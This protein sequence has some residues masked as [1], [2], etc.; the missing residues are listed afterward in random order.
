MRK[1]FTPAVVAQA[2]DREL[3]EASLH[4]DE[5]RRRFGAKVM[6]SIIDGIFDRAA[7]RRGDIHAGQN[8]PMARYN[9]LTHALMK[10]MREERVAAAHRKRAIN[11]ARERE[12]AMDLYDF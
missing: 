1:N 3:L 6:N 10:E 9:E 5:N 2:H 4:N 8:M 11:Q 12:A 7:K